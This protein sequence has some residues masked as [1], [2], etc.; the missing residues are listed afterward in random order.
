MNYGRSASN[1]TMIQELPELND[2]E[3]S[4][5]QQDILPPEVGN[6]YSKLI[7]QRHIP[8][9]QAG[10]SRMN[11]PPPQPNYTQDQESIQGMPYNAALHNISCLVISE[12]IKDCPICSKFYNN[13]NTIYIIIIVILAIICLLLLKKVLK[14]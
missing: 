8:H 13:D 1:V 11:E 6:K 5:I 7:R 3:G 4:N 14:V 12:H 9:A 2:L 10:M